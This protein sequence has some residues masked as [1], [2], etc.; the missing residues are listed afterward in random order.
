ML[1][2]DVLAQMRRDIRI[3]MVPRGGGAF[4]VG[5]VSEDPRLATRV[6]EELASLFIKQNLE[7]RELLADVTNQFLTAQLEDSRRRLI[8]HEKKLEE[9]RRQ[10]GGR[11][12]TQEASNLQLLQGAQSQLNAVNEASNRDRDRLLFLERSLEDATA[13]VDALTGSE[14]EGVIAPAAGGAAAQAL[15]NARTELRGLEQRLRP[16]HPDVVRLQRRIAELEEKADLEALSRPAAAAPPVSPALRAAQ[17][18]VE[19]IRREIAQIQTR[20]ETRKGDEAR[21]Q[22]AIARYRGRLESI[23][24]LQ[25]GLTE[26]MR[27]YSTLQEN[28][29]SLLRK[30]EESKLAVSLERRQVGQQFRL[31]EPPRLP[32]R[33]F[34]PNRQR[35][36]LMGL[37]AGL[38]FGL[39][40]AALLEYRDTTLKTDEDVV[41]SLAL[42]VVAVI[43]AMFTDAERRRARRRRLAVVT[44]SLLVAVAGA[45]VA[46]WQL[47]LLN[48]VEGWIR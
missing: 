6:A 39:G 11:L 17:G 21:V 30:S 12:P 34:A 43:P 15:Q 46:A 38:A 13:T 27:D 23:P 26:L 42:P 7:N 10:N 2:E 9:F 31:L 33:P 44:A 32:Q 36:N 19:D 35:I 48:V 24:A 37:F 14:I 47:Q 41:V 20:L 22:D 45:A 18:R 40:I 16:A 29:A 5:F 28:Y 1:L 8:E 25:S 4:R 3:T